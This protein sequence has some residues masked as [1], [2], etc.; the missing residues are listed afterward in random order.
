MRVEKWYVRDLL[1]VLLLPTRVW[2]TGSAKVSMFLKQVF[3][4]WST[5][6]FPRINPT[7]ECKGCLGCLQLFEIRR[8]RPGGIRDELNICD[9]NAFETKTS[10]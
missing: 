9:L 2:S 5:Q 4:L 6:N 10:P 7:G 3:V 1:T 8:V